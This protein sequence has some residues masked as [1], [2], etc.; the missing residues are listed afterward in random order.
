MYLE[1][2]KVPERSDFNLKKR[3]KLDSTFC[4]TY[5]NV[6]GSLCVCLCVPKDLELIRF[7]IQDSF[8]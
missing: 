8:S 4:S 2:E 1:E 6:K 3:N 5:N 7:H